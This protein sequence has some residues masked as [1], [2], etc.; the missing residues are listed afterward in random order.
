MEPVT[1]RTAPRKSISTIGLRYR[2]DRV[3][4]DYGHGGGDVKRLKREGGV[5]AMSVVG[6]SL[7]L[8]RRRLGA[9]GTSTHRGLPVRCCPMWYVPSH[10]VR[11][12]AE[13]HQGGTV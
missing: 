4:S 1:S 2:D 5:N 7:R 12:R 10:A 13:L 6:P 8:G 11:R 9:R 3:P